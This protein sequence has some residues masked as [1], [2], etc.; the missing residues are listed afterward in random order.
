MTDWQQ[1]PPIAPRRQPGAVSRG[2]VLVWAALPVQVVLTGALTYCAIGTWSIVGGAFTE[3]LQFIG[4]ALLSTPLTI[5][6]FVLGLPLRIVPRARAWWVRRAGWTFAVLG[7][8][9]AGMCLSYVV[10]TA[11]PVHTPAVADQ[12]ATDG[13]TPDARVFLTALGV[14][15]FASMHLLPPLRRTER[16]PGR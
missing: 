14:F 7:V 4:W 5:L 13:Y 12:P 11:G 10:G 15:A 2:A 1:V 16:S 6:V 8:A 9:V 3:A